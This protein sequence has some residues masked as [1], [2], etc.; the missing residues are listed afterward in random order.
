M[1]SEASVSSSLFIK[2]LVAELKRKLL[3][4]DPERKKAETKAL[5]SA[6]SEKSTSSEEEEEIKNH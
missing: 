3:R 5:L 1:L 6:R 4:V 2:L